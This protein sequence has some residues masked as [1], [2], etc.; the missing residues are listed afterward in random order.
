[1]EIINYLVKD[2]ST[3]TYKSLMLGKKLLMTHTDKCILID[4]T[5][6]IVSDFPTLQCFQEEADTRFILHTHN[7]CCTG[8]KNVLV[9]SPDTDVEILLLS[10][11]HTFD[12]R[13]LFKSGSKNRPTLVDIKALQINWNNLN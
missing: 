8:Y 3:D 9:C 4:G 7:A 12:G 13:V 10:F 5:S 1:M 6:G 2:W 11:A